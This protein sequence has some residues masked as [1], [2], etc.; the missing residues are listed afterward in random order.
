M[1]TLT[2]KRCH[3]IPVLAIQTETRTRQFAF[4]LRRSF[5]Y[6]RRRHCPGWDR[7]FPLA[8]CHLLPF[9]VSDIDRARPRSRLDMADSPD[10]GPSTIPS[11]INI[12]KPTQ[13]DTVHPIPLGQGASP[14]EPVAGHDYTE[15]APQ[16]IFDAVA[17]ERAREEKEGP[18]DMMVGSFQ[19][20]TGNEDGMLGYYR[21]SYLG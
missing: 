21:L 1:C 18:P 5:P 7:Y 4:R 9:L 17:N 3:M 6:Q 8:A 20:W 12:S 11:A 2:R 14:V 13:R 19:E 10:P 15:N 16:A